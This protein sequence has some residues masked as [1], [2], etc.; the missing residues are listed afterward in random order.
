MSAVMVH[1][2]S[3]DRWDLLQPLEENGWQLQKQ[4]GGTAGGKVAMKT[5]QTNTM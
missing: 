2:G 4:K 3:G 5:H 1:F